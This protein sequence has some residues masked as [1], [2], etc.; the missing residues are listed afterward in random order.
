MY[1]FMLKPKW[2]AFHVVCLA[3][4]VAMVLLGLWQLRRLDERTS[5]ND[6]VAANDQAES[7]PL[8]DLLALPD[9]TTAE[10]RRAEAVGQYL[11]DEFLV[12]NVTQDGVTGR[13]VVSALLMDDGTILIVNRGFVAN[14]ATVPPAPTGTVEVIGRLKRGQRARTGQPSD[15]GSQ[16]LTEIRRVDLTALAQQFDEPIAPMY[17]EL[18][19]SEPAEPNAVQM[20]K[21]P[22]LDSGPHLSYAIQWA[23]FTICV[24]AGWVLAVRRQAR[25]AAGL[26][27]KQRRG[28]PPIADEFR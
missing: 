4:M 28:P 20:I 15:D 18:V 13:D 6:R 23:I 26:P 2:L 7:A 11:P 25:E 24:G 27:P 21:F 1:R 5:F 19:K 10:Y 9:P 8:A 3:A 16:P 22:E 12:V 17:I 14:D